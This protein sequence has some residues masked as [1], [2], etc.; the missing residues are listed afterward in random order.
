MT[1]WCLV[2]MAQ[3]QWSCHSSVSYQDQI[4]KADP[5]INLLLSPSPQM[6][7]YMAAYH[8]SVLWV[9]QVMREIT[10]KPPSEIQQMEFVN[11]NFFRNTT[12]NGRE[13]DTAG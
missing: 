2:V 3:H 6:N 7:D 9:G 8:D 11:V 10:E 13:G 12:F 5:S 1:S 4:Q